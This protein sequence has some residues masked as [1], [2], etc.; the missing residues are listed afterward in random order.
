[1]K[2]YGSMIL[3]MDETLVLCAVD[4]SGRPYFGYQAEFQ[5]EQIGNFS[6]EMI[7]EF[8]YAISYSGAMNLH[9]RQLAGENAHHIAEGMFKAF[10]RALDEA[11]SL[12]ARIQEVLSTKGSL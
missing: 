4:L 6:T 12:D 5:A 8:F 1:M 7:K 11:T 10:A 3:P 9:L 2:R